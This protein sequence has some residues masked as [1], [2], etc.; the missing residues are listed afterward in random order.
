MAADDRPDAKDKDA[1]SNASD[2]TGPVI[3]K[4][5]EGGLA[6]DTIDEAVFVE[7]G[8]KADQGAEAMPSEEPVSRDI[9]PA[10]E[11][12]SPAPAPVAQPSGGSGGFV[13]MVVG[14]LIAGAIGYGV[15]IY[16]PLGGA[17]DLPGQVSA[18]KTEAAALKERITAVESAPS[19]AD[20][21]LEA[22]LAALEAAP[23]GAEPVDLGP[24]QAELAALGD[25]LSALDARLT[26]VEARPV[27]NEGGVA[28]ASP[29]MEAALAALRQEV[30]T[31]KGAGAAA[32]A[33]IEA[34]AAEAQARLAE[35]EEKAAQLKAEAEATA[36][37]AMARAGLGRIQAALESGAPFE[38][39]LADLGAVEVPTILAEAAA[40]G[41]P[42]LSALEDAFPPAARSALEA[43]LR[44]NTGE[45]WSERI[46]SFLQSTT[47]ARSLTP[48]DGN[49]PDAILSRAEAA[50]KTDDLRTSLDELAA[51][52]P[53]GQAAMADWVAQATRRVDAVQ[54]VA[55]LTTAI[56]G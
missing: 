48:R 27:S 54:A 38:S 35:A 14:G 2:E 10:S 20:P 49:D 39:A 17:S 16:A 47:G 15:A 12:A 56:G 3:A 22:R 44:A 26:V 43:S 53:E 4:E 32:T 9:E 28:T 25:R 51:L 55:E 19:G 13:G 40:A 31:L 42:S 52:P 34:M 24:M 8:D 41:I 21:A 46:G 29:D 18:L 37:K 11:P 50:L 30:E 7:D 36:Q 45:T 1:L 5:P 33:D 23:V 6:A